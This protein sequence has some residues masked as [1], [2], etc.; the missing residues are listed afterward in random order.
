MTVTTGYCGPDRRHQQ[1]AVLTDRRRSASLPVRVGGGRLLSWLAVALVTALVAPYVARGLVSAGTLESV[2]AGLASIGTALFVSAGLSYLLRWRLTG[3][4]PVALVGVALLVYGGVIG[5]FLPLASAIAGDS[6][7]PLGAGGVVRAMNSVVVMTLLVRS[8]SAPIVDSRLRPLR[9]L[10]WSAGGLTT[11]FVVV[12]LASAESSNPPVPTNAVTPL[13]LA[14]AVGWGSVATLFVRRAADRLQGDVLWVG[15]ALGCLALGNLVRALPIG[16]DAGGALS[17]A[18]VS[19]LAAS[20][21]LFGSARHLIE[22]LGSLGS[23]RL[24]L[25]IALVDQEAEQAQREERLHDVRSTL[26]AIRCAAGTLQRYDGKLAST[27]KA[28]LQSAVSSE[29]VRLERLIDPADHHGS[30]VFHLDD[31]LAGVVETER[32]Q[33]SRIDVDLRAVRAFGRPEDTAAIVQNLLVNARR[34]AAGTPISVTSRRTRDWVEVWVQD[35]GPGLAPAE[36]VEVF[37]RGRR[38][39]AGERAAGSGLGL[40][41]SRRLAA[42]QGGEL[43][44]ADSRDAGACFVLRLPLPVPEQ[45]QDEHSD[46]ATDLAG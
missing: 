14:L 10:A 18:V 30:R 36:R 38:G 12:G 32:V 7:S 43:L 25:R 9:L 4:A 13:F 26:A 8:L 46:E 33:G 41:V 3:E 28:T 44:V 31:A 29:L 16:H 17:A 40:F 15:V 39:V 42:E 24:R 1:R 35:G 19:L 37:A 6:T 23:E 34:Y 11:V 45:G 27:Q 22:L 5:F 21:A 2:R 20:V